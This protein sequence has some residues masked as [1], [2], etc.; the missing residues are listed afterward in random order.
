[1]PE[2]EPWETYAMPEPYNQRKIYFDDK[3]FIDRGKPTGYKKSSR[4]LGQS[5]VNISG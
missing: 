4:S 1:M 2:P 5:V 3:E